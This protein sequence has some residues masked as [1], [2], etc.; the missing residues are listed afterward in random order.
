MNEQYKMVDIFGGS[1]WDRLTERRKKSRKS[2]ENYG[3]KVYS[4]NDEDGII[5][6]IFARIGTT[7]QQ[8]VEFGVQDGL[9]SN[10]HL[11]LFKNWNGLW[12]EGD[13][14][15][16]KA[17]ECKFAPVI[18]KGKLQ[19]INAFI[20]KDNINMLIT[21]RGNIKGEIDLLSID[22]D[23]NDYYI[24]DAINVVNPRVVIV[25][26]NAKF[27]PDIDWKMAYNSMH[28]WDG[29]DWQ[30]ASLKAYELLGRKKGYTLVG[31]NYRGVNAFF[32][33]NDLIKNKFYKPS[34][35]ENLYNPFRLNIEYFSG[36]PDRY[37]LAFQEEGLGIFNYVD[38]EKIWPNY[39]FYEKE[40]L[41]NGYSSWI[42]SEKS[43]ILCYGSEK[44]KS[45]T[46]T[47]FMPDFIME[48]REGKTLK[49]IVLTVEIMGKEILSKEIS[50]SGVDILEI[51]ISNEMELE[52]VIS[53]DLKCS[54]LWIPALN[55]GNG[56]FRK[57]GIAIIWD[58]CKKNY[59]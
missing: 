59:Y 16:C 53:I 1:R 45:I 41:D 42:S 56:D 44:L 54:Y 26:Y 46:L 29:S 22:I 21:D 5:Q 58:K 18:K 43:E 52:Q 57:L 47:Y 11:L 24:W 6:E 36:H 17:I 34:T 31:T 14:G 23:G 8:F 38:K 20:T 13:E 49:P 12:I 39:G 7:N 9:E 40:L 37:C 10:G 15:Y 32:V 51:P 3:Y 28:V 50:S 48:E 27:P 35:A 25:E 2:L 4:Q 30:G 19:I 33:R 55:I